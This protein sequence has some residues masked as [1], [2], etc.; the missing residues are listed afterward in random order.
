MDMKKNILLSMILLALCLIQASADTYYY[1]IR[2]YNDNGGLEAWSKYI[3]V[4]H[5]E[6]QGDW[7]NGLRELVAG[8]TVK[9]EENN[10]Y[11]LP[12]TDGKVDLDRIWGIVFA[13]G[14]GRGR[15]EQLNIL[16]GGE[17]GAWEKI[18]THI[19]YL[20]LREYKLDPYTNEGYF[21][22]MHNVE[23]LELPKDGMTVGNGDNDCKYYFANAGN[24]KK[25]TIWSDEKND[26]VDITDDAVTDITDKKLLDRVGKY[27][28]ANCCSLSTK[29]INR[30]IKDV[31]EIKD[32]AFYV[33]GGNRGEF[34][35]FPDLVADHK[36]AIE[37]PTTVTKIGSQAFIID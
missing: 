1:K 35:K 2:L 30:L 8:N 12:T 20:E 24:L 37:I 15:N 4:S 31:T 19:K 6:L 9:D 25:I 18:R 10:T 23:E 22:N 27:M 16:E 21:M 33:D 7:V 36:M 32:N 3:P 28:F 34:D 13:N 26:H 5:S 14:K 17:F 11:T 29:Y